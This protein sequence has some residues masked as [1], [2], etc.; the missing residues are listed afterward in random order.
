MTSLKEE[1]REVCR[2]K[3]M[4][5]VGSR[6]QPGLWMT[7]ENSSVIPELGPYGVFSGEG[8]ASPVALL[9]PSHCKKGCDVHFGTAD[10]AMPEGLWLQRPGRGPV[11]ESDLSLLPQPHLSIYDEHPPDHTLGRGREVTPQ[12]ASPSTLWG[13]PTLMIALLSSI[14]VSVTST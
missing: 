11:A 13:T 8:R 10:P 6:A 14:S 12:Q 7:R 3:T 2:V 9:E 1:P 5:R 4:P